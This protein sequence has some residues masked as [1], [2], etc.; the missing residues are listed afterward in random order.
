MTTLFST[1]ELNEVPEVNA[2][3][4]KKVGWLPLLTVLFLISYGLMTMLIVEQGETIESQRALIRELF[5]DSTEL[6]A[7]KMKAQEEKNQTLAQNP[8]SQN[9]STQAPSTR[10]PQAPTKQAPSSQAG[11]QQHAQNQVKPKPQLQMPSKP[12]A[13]LADHRRALITI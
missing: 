8:S 13:D 4:R 12:A 5:R 6:S 3:P 1:V 9:P 2:T 7:V 11:P 10:I